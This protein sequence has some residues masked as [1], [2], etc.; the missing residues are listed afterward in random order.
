MKKN[1]CFSLVILMISFM[2]I[3]VAT[4]CARHQPSK[5]YQRDNLL[6]NNLN[7][8]LVFNCNE[9]IGSNCTVVD[10]YINALGEKCYIVYT[11]NSNQK[12]TYCSSLEE[13]KYVLL[14][15]LLNH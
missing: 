6:N 10:T 14:K 5:A 4:G 8:T 3:L 15:D 1:N 2:S 13:K 11:E 9:A 7:N 12:Q